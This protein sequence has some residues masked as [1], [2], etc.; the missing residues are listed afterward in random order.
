MSFAEEW[1]DVLSGPDVY[2]L[3]VGHVSGYLLQRL[4]KDVELDKIAW[5]GREIEKV[6]AG[7][8]NW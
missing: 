3:G 1:M 7:L 2:D 6:H 4:G 8:R 5:C